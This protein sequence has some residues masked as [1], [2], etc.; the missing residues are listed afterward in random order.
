MLTAASS[1]SAATFTVNPTQIF[2][3]SKATTSLLTLRNDSEE[4]LRFQLTAF[5]GAE[6]RAPHPRGQHGAVGRSGA[7]LPDLR[8]GAAGGR[9][10]AGERGSGAHE[11]GHPDL[12]PPR[13]GI[14][15]CRSARPVDP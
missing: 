12:H 13:E 5:A 6:R 9:G 14:G 7:D 15:D 3:S 4:T 1:A 2:L 11:D 8:R 10:S